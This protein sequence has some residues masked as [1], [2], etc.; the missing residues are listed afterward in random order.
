[1][2]VHDVAAAGFGS[3]AGA[4]ERARPTYPSEAVAW[5]T[6]ALGVREGSMVADVAAGTG[7][8]TRLLTGRRARPWSRSNRSAGCARSS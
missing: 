6:D 7:K 3:E 8:L 2:S 5:L 1:M 4:Y